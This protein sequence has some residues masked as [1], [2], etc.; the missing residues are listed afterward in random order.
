MTVFSEGTIKFAYD[1][2]VIGFFIDDDES[3]YHREG[4]ATSLQQ[5]RA[6]HS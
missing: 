2:I 5:A 6:Q 1:I 3:K 4:A